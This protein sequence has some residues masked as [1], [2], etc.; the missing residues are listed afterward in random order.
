MIVLFCA[1]R[2]SEP[3]ESRGVFK[4]RVGERVWATGFRVP[5]KKMRRIRAPRPRLC[6]PVHRLVAS[7]PGNR[8]LS[9]QFRCL[10]PPPNAQSEHAPPSRRAL[11]RSRRP[12]GRPCPPHNPPTHVRQATPGPLT[13]RSP[14]LDSERVAAATPVSEAHFEALTH[15]ALL[16]EHLPEQTQRAPQAPTH[17]ATGCPEA[18]SKRPTKSH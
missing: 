8:T 2:G 12:A 18:A 7:Q 15:L 3:V 16:G 5:P 14:P 1:A 11:L 13:A 10:T 6:E 17:N 9:L 4:H